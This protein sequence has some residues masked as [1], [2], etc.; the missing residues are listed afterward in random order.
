MVNASDENNDDV[1]TKEKTW[2]EELTLSATMQRVAKQASSGESRKT[3]FSKRGAS[4]IDGGE[5]GGLNQQD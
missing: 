1:L 2:N 3:G 4:R 5:G